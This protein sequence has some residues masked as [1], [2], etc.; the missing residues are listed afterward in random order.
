MSASAVE[1]SDDDTM[2]ICA[3][4]GTAGG[5]DI[6][7]KKC[8]ACHLVRYCGVKCQKEHRPK[9]KKECKKR[10][11]ELYDELLFKQPESSYN[12]DCPIC[13]LPLPIDPQKSVLMPCC[14][15][16]ICDG[17]DY[18][19]TK[20][21]FESN[22]QQKCPFCR[23]ASP[24]T[25][26]EAIRQCMKRIEMNDPVAMCQ[27]GTERYHQG[28]YKAAFEY[29]TKAVALGDA[30]A[31]HRLALLYRDGRGVGKD[32]KKELHHLKEA[33]I[34]G[35]PAARHEL[36]NM[37]LKN[38]QHTRAAKHFIIAAKLGYDKSLERVK[39]LHEGG[40]V[41]KEDFT[42]AHHGHK[43][44]IDATKSPQREEAEKW[45]EECEMEEAL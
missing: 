7:L 8:T 42:S 13:Y 17:C 32:K 31:H 44:A 10:A 26:E 28:D 14:I 19:N 15:K 36:G 39:D 37:D 20:R 29:M 40:F 12:G 22:L 25:Q 16:L 11:A 18:T 41:S 35:H 45:R 2:M 38:G 9:H 5:E 24:S 33:A 34:G 43:A 1:K 4:C 3:S 30:L 27:M 6:K 23:N 21:E